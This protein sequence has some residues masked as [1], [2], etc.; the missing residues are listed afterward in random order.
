MSPK[1]LSLDA[2]DWVEGPL[3][4]I[5]GA[6]RTFLYSPQGQRDFITWNATEVMVQ[7]ELD[8]EE[9]DW[10][11]AQSLMT[12][13][14]I[15]AALFA[16]A[17]FVNHIAEAT[18]LSDSLPTLY[19]IAEHWADTAVPFMNRNFPNIQTTVLGDHMMFWEHAERFNSLL[20]E[21]IA[22]LPQGSE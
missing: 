11:V 12:P 3:D 4:E 6:Y 7:R 19:L 17:M 22:S 16:D 18:Q 15:A 8:E 21:F 20:E 2:A 10:I 5:A 14:Y 1:P 9:L 13:H